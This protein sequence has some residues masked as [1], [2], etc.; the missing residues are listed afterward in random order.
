MKIIMSVD[1]CLCWE[2]CGFDVFRQRSHD[3]VL[4]LFQRPD[5]ERDH[6]SVVRRWLGVRG[7]LRGL[8]MTIAA[9]A[10]SVAIAMRSMAIR[11]S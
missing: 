11:M 6:L 9:M 4:V 7:G 3:V 1:R 5:E 10:N 8:S 2:V